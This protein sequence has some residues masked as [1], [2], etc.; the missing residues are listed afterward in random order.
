M[1]SSVTG[2][3]VDPKALGPFYWVRNLVSPVL[4]TDA[5]EELVLPVEG[6]GESTVDTLIEVG[7]HGALGG[8]VEQI[9]GHYGIKNVT[10][11]SML[12]RGQD[13]LDNALKLAS[14][15]FLEGAPVDIQKANGDL[16]S[17][18]LTD[19]PPYPW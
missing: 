17:R 7:P 2:S 11:H 16:S 4:F 15:L 5:L 18:L 10:H 8:P 9:L 12:T 13:A 6:D 3:K 19:L 1:V 14:G